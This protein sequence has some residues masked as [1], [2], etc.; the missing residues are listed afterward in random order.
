M[1]ISNDSIAFKKIALMRYNLYHIV[2]LFQEYNL[3]IFSI[4]TKLGNHHHNLTLEHFYFSPKKDLV[5]VLETHIPGMED[6]KQV[7]TNVMGIFKTCLVK[8]DIE[9]F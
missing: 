7:I 8:G 3:M 9:I 4:F 2:H 5:F 6:N 1:A